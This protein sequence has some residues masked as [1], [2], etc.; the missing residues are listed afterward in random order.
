MSG[1]PV[2]EGKP[3]AETTMPNEPMDQSDSHGP[4]GHT[5][6]GVSPLRTELTEH[7]PFSVSSVALGL[8]VAGIICALVPEGAVSPTASDAGHEGLSGG[9]ATPL[10]HLFHPSHTFF[11]AAATTA[12]FWRYD[13]KLWLA[14]L[15]GLV[16]AIGVCG[17]SDILMPYG[18]QVVLQAFGRVTGELHLHICVIEEPGLV[19]PFAVAGVFVGLG[20]A[21]TVGRSTLFSH[22]LHVFTST[23]ASIFYLIGP[24][25]RLAWIDSLGLVFVFVIAAVMIPCCLSD[26]VFPLAATKSVRHRMYHGGDSHDGSS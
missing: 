1:I 5:H 17:I 22:S 20:A 14:V 7:L 25:D 10:F 9:P 23:M 18:S 2:G 4:D 8:I 19:L 13:R 24:F 11:S 3:D 21:R 12:M 26:I 6:N 15:I 16:G